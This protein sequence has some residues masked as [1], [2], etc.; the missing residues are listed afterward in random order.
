LEARAQRVGERS[1]NHETCHFVR[2]P[3]RVNV[4]LLVLT[5]A[6]RKMCAL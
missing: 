1:E 6:G 4:R 5:A 3:F 2:L